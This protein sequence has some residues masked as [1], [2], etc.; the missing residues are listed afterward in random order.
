[1]HSVC[2]IIISHPG[3][4]CNTLF[5]FYLIR[6]ERKG[7]RHEN[8][9]AALI[10]LSVKPFPYTV[11][12]IY[13]FFRFA[14]FRNRY[15]QSNSILHP[16]LEAEKLFDVFLPYMNALPQKG[17]GLP[18]KH[19][20]IYAAAVRFMETHLDVSLRLSEIARHVGVCPT[21]LN[22]LRYTGISCMEF[23]EELRLTKPCVFCAKVKTAAKPVHFAAVFLL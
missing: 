1:M 3:A 6:Y 10:C 20:V 15:R 19:A 9:P 2:E 14:L 18:D 8:L 11:R 21:T 7:N 5:C 22:I 16:S 17:K 13:A 23:F 4:L 12:K